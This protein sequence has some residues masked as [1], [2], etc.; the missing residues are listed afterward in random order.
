MNRRNGRQLD[1]S[2][3]LLKV[4]DRWFQFSEF[5]FSRL[6]ELKET[7]EVLGMQQLLWIDPVEIGTDWNRK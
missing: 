6:Q 7:S 5:I 4:F 3:G 1:R 2:I